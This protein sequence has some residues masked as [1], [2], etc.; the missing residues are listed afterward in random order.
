[1]SKGTKKAGASRAKVPR[2]KVER[3]TQAGQEILGALTRFR[4]A[5][6]S[7]K[8]LEVQ[9]TVRTVRV[10]AKP[11]AKV[12]DAAAVKRVR[13]SLNA[14]QPLFARFLDVTDGTLRSW[15]QGRRTPSDMANRFLEEIEASPDHWKARFAASLEWAE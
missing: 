11:K 12:Y 2:V 15:E 9:F 1:M 10:K 8:P 5:I 4:D 3:P 7:G 14:S 13:D 6:R